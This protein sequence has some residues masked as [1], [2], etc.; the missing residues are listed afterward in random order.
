MPGRHQEALEVVRREVLGLVGDARPRADERHVAA[1]HVDELRQLVEA[2]LAQ[3]AP[4]GVTASVRSSLYRPFASGWASEL[5][6]A[7]M[8]SRCA[9]LVD[10]DL[11]RPELEQP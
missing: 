3:P 2:R 8:Y 6:V 11:H 1:E 9:C 5:I 10:V 7:L 4:N